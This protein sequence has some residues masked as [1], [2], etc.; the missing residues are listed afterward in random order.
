MNG[1]KAGHFYFALMIEDYA[2]ARQPYNLGMRPR[3]LAPAFLFLSAL[4]LLFSPPGAAEKFDQLKATGY[5]DDFAGVLIPAAK[6]QLTAL[7]KEVDTKAQAQIA[8]V[9]IHSLDGVPIEEFANRLFHRWGVGSKGENRG[10]LILLAVRDHKY[11]VEVGFGLEPI[12][13]DGKVGG[14]GREMVPLLRQ[15]NYGQALLQVTSAVARV[16]AD[17]RKVTLDALGGQK[18]VPA[19]APAL[20]VPPQA[21]PSTLGN[22]LG[23]IF[24]FLVVIIFLV[25]LPIVLLINFL[26]RLFGRRGPRNGPGGWWGWGSGGGGGGFDG[27]SGGG[28]SGDFG[29]FGGGDSGGGGA[30]G[31]W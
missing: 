1:Q 4:T 5:V 27:G 23:A 25:I 16:I 22:V 2:L 21:S 3:A 8:V 13:P 9:T 19:P 31:D 17:D 15:N 7:C 14:F 18:P 29:G 12:L 30:S 26:R 24:L 6:A 28:D 11:R 20:P 10:V